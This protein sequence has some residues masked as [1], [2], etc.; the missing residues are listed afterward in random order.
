MTTMITRP[1]AFSRMDTEI[2]R[3]ARRI[4]LDEVRQLY[5]IAPF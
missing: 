5:W 1:R 4:P 3:L 2:A